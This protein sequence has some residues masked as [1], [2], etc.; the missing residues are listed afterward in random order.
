LLA[1]EIQDQSSNATRFLAVGPASERAEAGGK[2]SFIVYPN[3]D[4]PGLLLELL[5]P[6]ADRDINLTR[7]ES[8]PSGERLGD[9]VFHIDVA[10]GLYEE[11]TQAAVEEISAICEDGWVRHLGSY[12][13]ETVID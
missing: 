12:D 2:T 6:F 5:H 11:R 4:Y 3:A 7:V 1:E 13:S 10:A 8:R 9:Y